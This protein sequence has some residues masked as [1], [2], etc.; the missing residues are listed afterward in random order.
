MFCH[1]YLE[2]QNFFNQAYTLEGFVKKSYAHLG[3]INNKTRCK[4]DKHGI[5]MNF[6]QRDSEYRKWKCINSCTTAGG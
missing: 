3:F 4:S 5:K 1:K 2:G 6:L